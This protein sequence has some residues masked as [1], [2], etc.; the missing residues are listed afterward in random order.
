MQDLFIQNYP[1][2]NKPFAH[3]QNY[4]AKHWKERNVALFAD[5]G[6]G[7]SFMV[8]NNIAMLYD[9]GDINAALIVAPKGVYRNWL[10]SEIPKHMP[11]HVVH[12]MA[13]WSPSPRK[14]ESIAL[15]S[16]FDVTEDLKILIMNIE[17]LSTDKGMKYAQRFLMYH[18]PF[19][20]IDESTTIK[21]PKA[22]RAKNAVKIGKLAKFRRIMT[23]SP[24]TKSPLDL[25][26]QCDFLSSDCLQTTSF[27]AFRARYAITVQRTMG[28]HSFQKVIGYQRLDELQ[29]K[30]SGFAFRVTKEECL[31]L[32][33]KMYVKREVALTPEQV[34]VY[35]EMKVMA[36]A[37]FK[38]GLS[39]TVNALTQLLRLH[40]IVCGHTKLDDGTV[41]EIPNNRIDEML[42][43]VEEA[44]GKIIIWANYRHDIEAIKLALQ[45][46]YGMNSVATY[47]G[48]TE[49]G[50][51]QQIVTSFQDP[52]HDLRF[53]VGN[54]RTGGYGLT[55]TAANVVIYYSNSFD[56]EVRLQSEDRAHRIGQTKSVTY[57]D[58]MSPKTV[59]E[60]IVKA[61]R[62]KINIADQVMG[63]EDLR[64]WLI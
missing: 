2:K 54:P 17:A 33:P 40:Q 8:I 63:V 52:E 41:V 43:V 3:Q 28:N 23:G 61:L 24:V 20:A 39:T 15:D 25:F 18:K 29:E 48:D 12:R 19:M 53:F 6:T 47:Y 31:D 32:P 35:N 56:L 34:R 59:D 45:K 60:K 64:A 57:V 62:D 22:R 42:S 13:L 36:L 46:E 44:S 21:T 58:L 49:A 27:Y 16:L 7:K 51:R 50:D 37:S 9:G 55:L 30:L 11:A 14:A 38:E 4:L 5:M 10:E 1:Y 26:Q